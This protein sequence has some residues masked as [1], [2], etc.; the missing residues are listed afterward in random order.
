MRTRSS[1]R[2]VPALVASLTLAFL[3][4]CS[5][6]TDAV[7]RDEVESVAASE[8]AEQVGADEPPN[9]SCPEDLDA[10][11]GATMTCEL[12]VEGDDDVYPVEIK[13]TSVDDGD[14]N[15]DVEVEDTPVGG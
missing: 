14:V 6:G 1:T 12:S 9:I 3:V 4:G 10:E 7:S 5:F 8:L 15:F 2:L 13:V 11:V